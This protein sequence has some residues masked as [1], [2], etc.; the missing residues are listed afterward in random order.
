MSTIEAIEILTMHNRWRRGH[1]SIDPTDPKQLGLA[2]ERA[3]AVMETA[4]HFLSSSEWNDTV[5][6]YD[7]FEAAVKGEKP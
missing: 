7:A 4:H 1:D 2:I 3:I 5:Q 6:K